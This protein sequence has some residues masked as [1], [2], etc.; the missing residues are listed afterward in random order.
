MSVVGTAKEIPRREKRTDRE[1]TRE[2]RRTFHVYTNNA[3]DDANVV[4][5]A[6]GLPQ[7]FFPYTSS[8]SFDLQALCTEINPRQMSGQPFIWEV[9]VV[10]ST[11]AEDEEDEQENPLAEPPD[12]EMTFDSRRTVI[13]GTPD[14]TVLT[15]SGL[16]ITGALKSSN[17]QI[18]DPPPEYDDY[19]PVLTVERNEA[20][21]NPALAVAFQNAVNEDTFFGAPPRSANIRM[22][23]ARKATKNGIKFA[24]VRY[25]IAFKRE[26]WDLRLLNQ[27]T[28]Y[29]S[30]NGSTTSYEFYPP[31]LR[32]L[33][34]DGTKLGSTADPTFSTFRVRREQP[35][36]LLNLPQTFIV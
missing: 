11:E 31:G 5:N 14:Q 6:P 18:F 3:T 19:Y 2:Y 20:S 36:G 28:F 32:N 26:L 9:E 1:G 23:G 13:V 30:S 7:R 22:I 8:A 17:G 16:S 21:F 24:R 35:F 27:G 29:L 33:A 34:A 15:S 25:V 12:M 10:Y 4:Q